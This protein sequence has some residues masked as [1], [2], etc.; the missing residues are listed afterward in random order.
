MF[1][2]T[3]FIS[4]AEFRANFVSRVITDSVWYLAQILVFETLYSHFDKIGGLTLN[5]SRV[6]LGCL[7]VADAIYM[8]FFQDNLDRI[9]DRV[10]KGELDLILA[11]PI[12]SQF[13]ISCQKINTAIFSNLIIAS[14]FLA[15]ALF[16]IENLTLLQILMFILMTLVGSLL[17]YSIKFF[18]SSIIVV[19]ARAENLTF[20]FY[21]FYR[22]GMK[23]DTIYFP[24][25]RYI[26]ITL[27]PMAFVASVPSQMLFNS[28]NFKIAALGIFVSASWLYITH[29]FWNYC[30]RH[31]SSA[32]S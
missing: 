3:S 1:L 28:P 16:K 5:Q 25:L 17:I 2:K 19:V 31:Y 20:I 6:F 27:L 26:L 15:W 14:S 29:K 30:L 22:L 10:R 18:I 32:S 7:F 13:M 4:D 12:N 11:K 9:S 23:P 24:W 21:Q 8:I